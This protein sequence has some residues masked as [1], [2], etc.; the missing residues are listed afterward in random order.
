VAADRA[1]ILLGCYRTGEAADPDV[2][3]TGVAATLARYSEDVVWTVTDP[4]T[5]LPSRSN[6]LPTIAEVRAACE[7]EIAPQRRAEERQQRY[8]AT[9]ALLVSHVP[10]DAERER[11]NRLIDKLKAELNPKQCDP[12]LAR[13]EAEQHLAKLARQ[14]GAFAEPFSIGPELQSKLD[15]Y[16]ATPLPRQ[17][18]AGT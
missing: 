17:E 14:G 8:G 5:G 7:A 9:R 18:R 16:K 2:Y 15:A 10:D 3:V 6:W 1:A 4:R 12:E 13:I 11:V